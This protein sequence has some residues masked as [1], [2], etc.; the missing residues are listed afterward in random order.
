MMAGYDL[1]LPFYRDFASSV[2]GSLRHDVS[3]RR[4]GRKRF[5]LA[6]LLQDY[7]SSLNPINPFSARI[8]LDAHS[9]EKQQRYARFD[10]HFSFTI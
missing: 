2:R 10:T 6:S 4:I 9:A 8:G 1:I 5:G 7:F 3:Y